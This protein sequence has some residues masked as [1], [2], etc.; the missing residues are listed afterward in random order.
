MILIDDVDR[1]EI[2]ALREALY[3]KVLDGTF[4]DND[5]NRAMVKVRALA[6]KHGINVDDYT[7]DLWSCAI[8]TKEEARTGAIAAYRASIGLVDG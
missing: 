2:Q 1:P 7:F 5:I 4:D 3:A 8:F 6:N